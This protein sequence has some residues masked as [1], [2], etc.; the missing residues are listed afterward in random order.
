[1][2]ARIT[3]AEKGVVSLEGE[4]DF[5]T[6]MTLREALQH[7]VKTLSG[8]L[9]LDMSGVT[10]ANSVALSL[11]LFVAREL[12][13]GRSLRVRAM[14]VGLQSIARVCELDDWLEA[15]AVN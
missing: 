10:R 3:Q 1:M 14:P 6:A 12:G 11:L 9:T 8:D 15:L 2:T 13:T 4:I 5:T 7:Q